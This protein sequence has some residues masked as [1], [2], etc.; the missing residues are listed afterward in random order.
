MP[1]KCFNRGRTEP[2]KARLKKLLKPSRELKAH[3]CT[4]RN[5][6]VHEPKSL[7][8]ST[9]Y[10]KMLYTYVYVWC[11]C[12]AIDS[13][14]YVASLL[15]Q[16]SPIYGRLSRGKVEFLLWPVVKLFAPFGGQIN[17]YFGAS[18]VVVPVGNDP[19]SFDTSTDRRDTNT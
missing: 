15:K 6:R 12:W 17:I 4:Y 2:T 18:K 7:K 1:I 19:I 8:I 13:S 14:G 3:V 9:Q 5:S 16:I 11:V 10:S